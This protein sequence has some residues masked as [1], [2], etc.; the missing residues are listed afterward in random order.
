MKPSLYFKNQCGNALFLILIAVALFAA[1]SYAI[2]QSGR[3]GGNISKE[4]T[5][6]LASEILQYAAQIEQAV[7]R[8]QV[9]NNCTDT[10]ISFLYDWNGDGQTRNDQSADH[11]NTSSPPSLGCGVFAD[12]GG[13]A[14]WMPRPSKLTSADTERDYRLNGNTIFIGHGDDN[15]SELAFTFAMEQTESNRALCNAI[16]QIV[17]LPQDASND[18]NYNSFGYFSWGGGYSDTGTDSTRIIGNSAGESAFVGAKTGCFLTTRNGARFI[19]YHIV[20]P[21]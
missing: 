2:T 12:N 19:F 3:G 1:L 4:T 5:Q 20:I 21:R 11:A 15:L 7:M 18:A 16:N 14:Y 8:V 13:Q 17:G 6:L 10:Q 9:I